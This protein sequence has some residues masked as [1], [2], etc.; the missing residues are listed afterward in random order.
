MVLRKVNGEKGYEIAM[1]KFDISL[2]FVM[3]NSGIE[4]K[5]RCSPVFAKGTGNV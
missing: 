3:I 5:V 2:H 4:Y 1:S